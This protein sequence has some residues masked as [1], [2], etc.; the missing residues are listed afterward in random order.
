MAN[1][2]FKPITPGRRFMSVSDFSEITKSKPE[3]SL[4]KTLKKKS[5]RNFQGKITVRHK[6]GG[7]RKVYRIIDWKRNKY[8]IEARVAAIEYDPNRSANIALLVYKDGE[9]SYILAPNGLKVGDKVMSSELADIK[10]G[11]SLPLKNIPLGTMIHN[12]EMQ[13]GRGAQLVRSAGA[14]AQLL[15]K[16]GVMAHLRLPS[17]EVRLISSDCY[18]TIG[19]V[20]NIEHENITIGKA[21]RTRWLGI[22][23]TNRGVSTNPCD[24]PHGGGEAKATPGRPST[25]PTGKPAYGLK[26]RGKRRS[27]KFIVSRRK[28]KSK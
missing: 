26:T 10:V 4:I 14:A 17:S 11:N 6:G 5:G 27:N 3:K 8:N 13:P 9:K 22:R 18:A 19:Q 16:E 1:K 12:V 24:H 25:T 21:G 23:P 2:N 28:N 7:A 15:A 20:G